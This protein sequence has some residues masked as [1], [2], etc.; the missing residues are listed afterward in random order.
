[1][2]TKKKMFRT[3]ADIIPE[4]PKHLEALKAAARNMGQDDLARGSNARQIFGDL[5]FRYLD[6][7]ET[8][9][10]SRIERMVLDEVNFM[11]EDA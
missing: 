3:A 6:G 8:M 7:M 2:A 4:D 10:E 1:M 9:D 5:C 11:A